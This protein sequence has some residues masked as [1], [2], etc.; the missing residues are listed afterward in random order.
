MERFVARTVV[1]DHEADCRLQSEIG[2]HRRLEEVYEGLERTLSR[3]PELGRKLGRKD[4]SPWVY[5]QGPDLAAGTPAVSALYT[6]D[7]DQ[8]FVHAIRVMNFI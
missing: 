5:S 6:F 7:S 8:V 2:S 1:L 4:D 3:R